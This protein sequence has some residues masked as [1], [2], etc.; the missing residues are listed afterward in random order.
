M[1]VI[2]DCS[3]VNFMLITE[4]PERIE[5]CL[6]SDWNNRDRYRNAWPGTTCGVRSAYKRIDILR[7]IPCSLRFLSA[8]PLMESVADINLEREIP[9]L[10]KQA[11]AFH[12]ERGINALSIFLADRSGKKVNPGAV[13]LIR[14]YPATEVPLLP[15]IEHGKRFTA[16]E[17]AEYRNRL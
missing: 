3:H 5:H 9:L 7:S 10:F 13:P 16:E 1:A 8:E 15:F 14:A 11:S 4:R 17:D 12:S 6:P 2:R